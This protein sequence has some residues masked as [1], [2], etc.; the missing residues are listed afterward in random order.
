MLDAPKQAIA[1][2][3]SV[4]R[5]S[6]EAV[7]RDLLEGL[8]MWRVWMTLSY[9]DIKRRYRRTLIGP[10]WTSLSHGIFICAMGFLFAKLWKI[11]IETYL[12]YLASGFVGWLY[13]ASLITDS[14]TVFT[15]NGAIMHQTRM[16]Y[17]FFVYN[18]VCRNLLVMAHHLAIY[19]FIVIFFPVSFNL[20]TLLL[21]PGLILVSLTGAWFMFLTGTIVA[22]FRDVQQIVLSFLQIVMFIT[23]IFWPEKMIQGNLRYFIIEPNIIFHAVSVIRL[24]LLGQAPTL[25][26]W[27][28]MIG[29]VVVGW[30]VTIFFFARYRKNLIFWI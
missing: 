25:T 24:P 14:C 4:N 12:P 20:N 11:D 15:T 26:N 29:L 10:W 22:R 18:Y 5:A 3:I 1:G 9:L 13:V 28:A 6:Y 27:L 8:S 21:I 16:P 7:L 30:A 2:H 19:T 17:S 23:P